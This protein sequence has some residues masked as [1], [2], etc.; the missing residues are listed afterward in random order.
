M[1][2]DGLA[3]VRDVPAFRQIAYE[4]DVLIVFDDAVEYLIVD[5]AR[6]R[7]VRYDRVEP[8]GIA[9]RTRYKTVRI[10]LDLFAA[11]VQKKEQEILKR[12]L[13]H[14]KAWKSD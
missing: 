4:F 8:P 7:V 12:F 1:K 10:S 5:R 6:C 11:S 3:V 9:D 13:F 2:G 14:Y